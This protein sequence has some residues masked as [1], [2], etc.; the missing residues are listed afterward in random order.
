MWSYYGQKSLLG[1]LQSGKGHICFTK[2]F[3]LKMAC[4]ISGWRFLKFWF[5]H[6]GF[7]CIESYTFLNDLTMGCPKKV[8]CLTNNGTKAF[9]LISEMLLA[10]DKRDPNFDVDVLFFSIEELCELKTK[11]HSTMKPEGHLNFTFVRIK[12]T[13]SFIKKVLFTSLIKPDFFK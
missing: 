5:F 12:L 11:M 4:E 1:A 10:L 2:P 3:L 9:C 13:V 8:L 7:Y 6:A